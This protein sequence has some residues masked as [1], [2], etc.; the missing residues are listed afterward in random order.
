MDITQRESRG[1]EEEKAREKGRD[2]SCEGQ[3]LLNLPCPAGVRAASALPSL[4]SDSLPHWQTVR[5]TS[6]E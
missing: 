1:G 4:A 3:R 6:C 5:G 2:V